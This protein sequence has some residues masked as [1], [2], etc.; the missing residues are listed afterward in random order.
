MTRLIVVTGGPGAGKTALLELLRPT[1]APHVGLLPEAA[2]ILFGGGFPRSREPPVRRAAQRAI[3]HVQREL[4]TL[5]VEQDGRSVIVCDRGTLDGLAYWPGD[6]AEL[7]SAV[8]TS[9]EGEMA[10]YHAVLHLRVPHRDA[11]NHNNPLRL[12]SHDEAAA[13]D[14]R[15]AVAWRGH[16]RLYVVNGASDFMDKMRRALEV[17][18]T[19]MG[20]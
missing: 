2:G 11:Y 3:F 12:E 8:G 17:L 7:L 9:R 1:L 18:R 16:P 19:L 5:G 10:R 4:E 14:E 13:I 6:P 15:I 20:M